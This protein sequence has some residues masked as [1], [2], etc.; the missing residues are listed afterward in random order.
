VKKYELDLQ[1][2]DVIC[3]NSNYFLLKLTSGEQL[4]EMRPGQFVEV[5]VDGSPSTFLRRP[6]SINFVDVEANE[7][8]LLIQVV[9]EGTRRLSTYRVG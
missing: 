3:F 5:R 9:G 7:L 6:V 8:W 4:P 1:V 2:K